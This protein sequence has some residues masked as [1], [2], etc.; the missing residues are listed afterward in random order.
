MTILLFVLQICFP[1]NALT[2]WQWRCCL[3]WC[4]LHLVPVWVRSN[5]L[6]AAK[7]KFLTD[8]NSQLI[9]S[10]VHFN[11]S[12]VTQLIKSCLRASAELH[13][14]TCL[15]PSGTTTRYRPAVLHVRSAQRF[16]CLWWTGDWRLSVLWC[17]GHPGKKKLTCFLFFFWQQR[18][19]YWQMPMSRLI[20]TF[21][22][23]GDRKAS[24]KKEKG[25]KS[26][27]PSKKKGRGTKKREHLGVF[28]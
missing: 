7:E 28:V 8:P 1:A 11:Y 22:L 6:L 17:D 9:D 4:L 21:Y 5:N 13:V 24:L 2:Y 19:C 27:D 3:I 10:L 16:A 25:R 12:T 23:C 20:F 26:F 18:A 15:C 14:E